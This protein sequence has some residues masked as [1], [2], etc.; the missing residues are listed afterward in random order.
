MPQRVNLYRMLIASPGDCSE[1]RKLIPQLAADWNAA[2][3][4]EKSI[5]IEPVL[6]ETH[7][8]P[9]L[10]ERPQAI[11]NRQL[12]NSCDFVVGVF[13]MRLGTP[14]GAAV[15]GTAEEI[16]E[17]REAGKP[18]LLYFSMAPIV[19]TRID[20][21]QFR[22]LL[23][24]RSSVRSTGL[25]FDYSGVREF[26]RIFSR[27]LAS[28]MASITASTIQSP[29]VATLAQTLQ[30]AVATPDLER[31]L[32]EALEKLSRDTRFVWTDLAGLPQDRDEFTA[33]IKDSTYE[34]VKET[35]DYLASRGHL[36]YRIN[37]AYE[38]ASDGSTVLNITIEQITTQLKNLAKHLEIHT[39]STQEKFVD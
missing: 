22:A 17:F 12:V 30:N 15:S 27:H 7:A 14:S 34:K 8:R 31:K 20:L 10:G 1:E 6:W 18:V 24:Y 26:E 23:D 21:D 5:I 28:L 19:P 9:E 11:I 33:E 3:T 2:H 37:K 4:S 25:T 36:K 16:E 38:M 39:S 32:I 35:L 29:S 13:W